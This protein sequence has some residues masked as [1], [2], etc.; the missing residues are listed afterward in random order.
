MPPSARRPVQILESLSCSSALHA[1]LALKDGCLR[2]LVALMAHPRV[3]LAL[4]AAKVLTN[5][6]YLTPRAQRVVTAH[7]ADAAAIKMLT[8]EDERCVRQATWLLSNLTMNDGSAARTTVCD[9]E[10]TIMLLLKLLSHQN[11][12]RP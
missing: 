9:N 2:C 4:N 6:T 7:G 8:H 5:I 1:A 12:E 11:G 3:G 10:A